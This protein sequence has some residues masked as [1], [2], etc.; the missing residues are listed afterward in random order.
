ML[1]NFCST[2]E[3]KCGIPLKLT[4][5]VFLLCR[6]KPSE[7]DSGSPNSIKNVAQALAMRP[8]L[9]VIEQQVSFCCFVV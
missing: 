5:Y 2:T 4:V 6:E 8:P 7:H 1:T 3:R 9:K